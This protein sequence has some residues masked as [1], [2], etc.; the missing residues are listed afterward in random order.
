MQSQKLLLADPSGL[1]NDPGTTKLTA[2][3][4]STQARKKIPQTCKNSS[5]SLHYPLETIARL[6]VFRFGSCA[7]H[8]VLHLLLMILIHRPPQETSTSL[9]RPFQ[10]SIPA[11]QVL[12]PWCDRLGIPQTCKNSSV[13]LHYPSEMIARLD[14]FRFG[15]CASNDVLHLL[16][17]SHSPSTPVDL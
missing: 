1:Q 9:K 17:I 16:L 8:D 15:S 3:R 10:V 5:V 14:V 7:S 2:Q 12:P 4:L 11:P 6:D 13:S